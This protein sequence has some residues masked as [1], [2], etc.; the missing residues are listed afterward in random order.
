MREYTPILKCIIDTCHNINTLILWNHSLIP[1][2]CL[3]PSLTTTTT[4][5]CPLPTIRR[6]C[7]LPHS[8]L[9]HSI[10]SKIRLRPVS[11]GTPTRNTLHS[12]GRLQ[13]TTWKEV[14]MVF[15]MRILDWT[16]K[17]FF[18][19]SQSLKKRKRIWKK[20]SAGTSFSATRKNDS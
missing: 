16:I 3:S 10:K 15:M 8:R 9:D 20:S 1:P 11:R 19:I 5:M 6:L 7:R 4:K 2:N 14:M 17:I 13:S 12:F 18:M